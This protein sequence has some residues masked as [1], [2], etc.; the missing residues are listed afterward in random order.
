MEKFILINRST[1]HGKGGIEM[2]TKIS[3]AIIGAFL[4]TICLAP[5]SLAATAVTF[6]DLD[7]KL[8]GVMGSGTNAFE[9]T[10]ETD[11]TWTDF[12]VNIIPGCIG[13][14]VGDYTGPGTETWTTITTPTSWSKLLDVVGLNIPD[15]G[16]YS[17]SIATFIAPG[18]ISGGFWTYGHPTTDGSASVPEP[19]TMLLLGLGLVGLAGIKRS[20]G[21]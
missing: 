9:V 8:L 18:P 10:N 14:S 3:I 13:C 21:I 2:R 20:M 5:I 6:T 15:E 4:I 12:H 16:V 11:V 7:D 17:F 1:L 19:T